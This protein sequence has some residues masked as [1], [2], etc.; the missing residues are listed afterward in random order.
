MSAPEK[1][2]EIDFE[3]LREHGRALRDAAGELREATQQALADA[4]GMAR[5]GVREHPYAVLGVA[6]AA[7]WVLAGGVPVKLA[8]LATGVVGRA[9]LGIAAARLAE[10]QR[11]EERPSAKESADAPPQSA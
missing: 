8:T 2:A 10:L 7:G 3:T 5:S 4:E 6:F 11:G 9:A 1:Q